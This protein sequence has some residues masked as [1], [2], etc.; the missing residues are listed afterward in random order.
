MVAAAAAVPLVGTLDIEMGRRLL[1][2]REGRVEPYYLPPAPVLRTLC[3]G[4]K[5]LGADVLW[6]RTIG[7]FSDHISG[8]RQ[9]SHL[10]RY[11]QAT[12]SLDK[13]FKAIYRFGTTMLANR[14]VRPS[15]A[16]IMAA[17]ALL[18]RGHRLYPDEYRFPLMIGTFYITELHTTIEPLRRRWRR[19]GADWVRRAALIG[20]NIPWLP[21]LAA[22]IYTE[23]GHQQLATRY[24]E[25]LY[26]VTSDKKTR[27]QIAAKLKQARGQ[28]LK[29]LQKQAE[30]FEKERKASRLRFLPADLYAL[31]RTKP[32]GPFSIDNIDAQLTR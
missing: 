21:A 32:L 8:D 19:E 25:E 5:E 16:Q 15:N 1:A 14:S 29:E 18:E 6:L 23:Q 20:A 11:L 13:H 10:R 3:F 26:L 12:L 4:Y 27:A 7:Y 31:L 2:G 17:I 30:A 9:L 28:Q 24:L 22:K